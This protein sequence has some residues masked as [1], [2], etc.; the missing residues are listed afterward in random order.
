[1]LQTHSK[2]VFSNVQMLY[3]QL[4][5][6][7]FAGFRN[8]GLVQVQFKQAV[9]K[10][11]VSA[12]LGTRFS[13]APHAAAISAEPR[14][15]AVFLS[16]NSKKLHCPGVEPTTISMQYVRF[17]QNWSIF[18]IPSQLFKLPTICGSCLFQNE[19]FD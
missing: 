17:C 16:K 10:H 7:S 5:I 18:V 19:S 9:P 14:F 1:M 6:S 3:L 8:I 12:V 13:A 11:A 15:L 2:K 4:F